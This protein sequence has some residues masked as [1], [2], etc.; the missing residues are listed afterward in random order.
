M[1]TI[2]RERVFIPHKITRN[3][4]RQFAEKGLT[5]SDF[6]RLKSLVA[7]H[8]QSLIKT[9]EHTSTLSEKGYVRCAPEWCKLIRALAASSPVCG[10]LHPSEKTQNLW[11]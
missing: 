7:I 3:L 8:A 1:Y 6:E 5:E 10:L 4:L 2:H 11:L 9:I